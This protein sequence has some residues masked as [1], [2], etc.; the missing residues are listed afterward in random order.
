MWKSA[1]DIG[2][3]GKRRS[4]VIIIPAVC[5]RIV[6]II[7]YGRED[8]SKYIFIHVKFVSVNIVLA[9]LVLVYYLFLEPGFGL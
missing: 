8:C 3:I 7:T 5:A 4:F 6:S 9:L 1:A 2:F